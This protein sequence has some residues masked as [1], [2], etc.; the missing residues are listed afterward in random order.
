VDEYRLKIQL[1]SIHHSCL[2]VDKQISVLYSRVF[3]IPRENIKKPKTTIEKGTK[4]II[5]VR[6]HRTILFH[7]RQT[8]YQTEYFRVYHNIVFTICYDF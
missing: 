4:L 5:V 1:Q 7:R 3:E 2:K 8:V 6:E